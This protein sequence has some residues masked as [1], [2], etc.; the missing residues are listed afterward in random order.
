MNG[1]APFQ[2]QIFMVCAA[3]FTSWLS[4][5]RI[6]SERDRG[7]NAKIPRIP[8]FGRQGEHGSEEPQVELR[9]M[10]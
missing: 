4:G 7:N 8:F 10:F 9:P 6:V 5:I 3:I 1:R 2:P